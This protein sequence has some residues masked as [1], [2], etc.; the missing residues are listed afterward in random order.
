MVDYRTES[1]RHIRMGHEVVV[2]VE[3]YEELVT[4]RDCKLTLKRKKIV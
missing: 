1:D 2:H 3:G 4:C